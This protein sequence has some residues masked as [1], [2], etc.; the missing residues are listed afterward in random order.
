[1][2]PL[3]KAAGDAL[4]IE[5]PLHQDTYLSNYSEMWMQDQSEFI[6][7]GA[8]TV[9]PVSNKS[10][11][12]VKYERGYFWRTSQVEPRPLAGAPVEAGYKFTTGTY[13][14]E[15]YAL[16]HLIDDRQRAN[17][18]AQFNLDENAVILLDHQ[19]MIQMDQKWAEIAFTTGVWTTEFQGVNSSPS[20]TQI[21]QFDQT[22]SDPVAMMRKRK[23]EF[24]QTTG[25]MPNTLVVGQKV[26]DTLMDHPDIVD[27]IKYTQTGIADRALLSS[28]FG[29]SNYYIPGSIVNLHPEGQSD[30][31]DWIIDDRSMLL[32]YIHPVAATNSPTAIA[33]FSWTGLLGSNA[34]NIAPVYYRGRYD[35][36]YT[37]YIHAKSAWDMRII[38]QDLGIFFH[39]AVA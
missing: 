19:H 23:R 20:A 8:T 39:E 35:D 9:I 10:D 18:D 2:A 37:D 12:Y 26:H 29:V 27:R 1:M 38:S 31:F 14:V 22:G 17:A 32:C 28:M 33:T 6:S 25:F 30:S 21:L 15:E 3:R 36:R 13:T 24:K 16:A 11:I 34:A 4:L 7:T 5:G